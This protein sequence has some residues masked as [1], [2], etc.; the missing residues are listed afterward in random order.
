MPYRLEP[1]VAGELGGATRLDPSQHP[2]AVSEVEYLLDGPE[3]DE[4]IESFPVFLVS[5]ALAE[6]LSVEGLTGFALGQAT[7][8][9]GAE[10]TAM[11]GDA[12]HP[13]YLWLR[14]DGSAPS[15]DAWLD[16]EYR[17]CVSDRM[18]SALQ[19]HRIGRCAIEPLTH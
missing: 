17:L 12:A 19:Q 10:Y 5:T 4:L 1:H 8:R 7:V 2:P 6:R 16:H 9:P 13:D 11:Y 14:P 3:A 15:E 18:M